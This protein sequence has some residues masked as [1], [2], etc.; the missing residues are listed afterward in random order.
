MKLY[1]QKAQRATMG[2]GN[3]T[4]DT[5]RQSQTPTRSTSR[6]SS[7]DWFLRQAPEQ[8]DQDLIRRAHLYFNLIAHHRASESQ[9]FA[10]DDL[11]ARE[12]LV[13]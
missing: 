7:L 1:I 10:A 13:K 6:F 11:H 5:T 2:C 12:A 9:D 3:S 4:P 8:Q